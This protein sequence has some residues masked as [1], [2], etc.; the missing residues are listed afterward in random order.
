MKIPPLQKKKTTP[1]VG[2]QFTASL[3]FLEVQRPAYADTIRWPDNITLLSASNISELHGKYTQLYCFANQGLAKINMDILRLQT[4]DSLRR[5]KIFRTSPHIN[6]QERW[7]RDTVIDSD[8]EIERITKE[9]ADK[10]QE[11]EFVQMYVN[12]YDR[13]LTALSRELSRKSH[14]VSRM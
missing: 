13:Y 9:I 12:N 10:K 1:V 6:S 2:N 11:R 4:E 14:D 7:R 3:G 8:P 5:N